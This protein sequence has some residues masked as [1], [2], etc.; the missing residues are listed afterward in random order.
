T[1]YKGSYLSQTVSVK[2]FASNEHVPMPAIERAIKKDMQNWK[3][4]SHLPYVH[5]LLGAST[6][7]YPPKLIAEYCPKQ[8]DGYIFDHPTQ[9]FRVLFELISGIESIHN[10]GVVHRD[11]APCNILITS[12]GTI[13][14]SDFGA[15]RQHASSASLSVPNNRIPSPSINFQ[16]PECQTRPMQKEPTD[17]WSFGMI[18]YYLLGGV[19]PY[20]GLNDQKVKECLRT[21][22]LPPP[23]NLENLQ[24]KFGGVDLVPLWGLIHL[25]WAAEPARRIQC[26]VLKQWLQACYSREIEIEAEKVGV[27]N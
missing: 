6:G 24:S 27:A 4:L 25:C 21:N 11:L 3:M 14:I 5:T 15:S 1:T 13:A 26:G 8:I 19:E 23:L 9:L 18:A 16:S 10:A 17:V 12:F 2:V 7:T 20:V 22:Q